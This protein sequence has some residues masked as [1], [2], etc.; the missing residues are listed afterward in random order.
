MEAVII[1]RR[2]HSF[3]NYQV[4]LIIKYIIQHMYLA[5]IPQQMLTLRSSKLEWP[6]KVLL[7]L[8]NALM[9]LK[10]MLFLN[11]KIGFHEL[12]YPNS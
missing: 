11:S 6:G 3:L 1:T 5:N 4:P 8:N 7:K 2:R 9:R 10:L 12:T